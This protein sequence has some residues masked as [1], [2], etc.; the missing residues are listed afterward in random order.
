MD[1]WGDLG[2]ILAGEGQGVYDQAFAKGLSRRRETELSMAK[3][4]IAMDE[5][6]ARRDL[7]GAL[8]AIMAPEEADA[9]A[10]VM[11]GGFNPSQFSRA[12][13]DNQKREYAELGLQLLQ[14]GD[15]DA[16]NDYFAAAQGKPI[17]RTKI[18]GNTVFDPFAPTTQETRPTDLG[19]SMIAENV[20]QAG[21]ASAR[22]G[23]SRAHADLRDRTDPNLR[24]APAPKAAPDSGFPDVNIQQSTTPAVMPG[25]QQL[26]AGAKQ[27]PDG[28]WYVPDPNRPGKWLLVEL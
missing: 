20:A 18:V 26:P 1:G 25:S 17:E 5:E 22:A 4:R 3:A 13:S 14:A 24:K 12:R 27:A 11:R 21:A 19:A 28:K 2:K 23:A 15:V 8:G 6:R 9:M 16:A 7:S 10:T